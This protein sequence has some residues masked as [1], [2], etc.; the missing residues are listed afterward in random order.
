MGSNDNYAL[1][2]GKKNQYGLLIPTELKLPNK[3]KIMSIS[4]YYLSSM[5]LLGNGDVY[6]WGDNSNKQLGLGHA[7]EVYTPQKLELDNII[8]IW[9][10]IEYS[11]SMDKS[12]KL[13]KFGKE[14]HTPELIKY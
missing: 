4:C 11:F 12:G 8:K 5:V 3:S 10:G 1:G 2:L 6:A 7:N 14:Y 9:C 13:Y